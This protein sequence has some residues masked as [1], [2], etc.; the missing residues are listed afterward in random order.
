[1][2]RE[3]FLEDEKYHLRRRRRL[4]RLRREKRLQARRRRLLKK[5]L[6]LGIVALSLIMIAIA[7]ITMVV[8]KLNDKKAQ[9][10][11]NEEAVQVSGNETEAIVPLYRFQKTEDTV[12]IQSEK[13]ISS[14]AILVNESTDMIL[15]V[16]GETER[17]SPASMTKVLTILVAAEHISE[18]NMSDT[19]PMTVEI[20]DYILFNDC[21]AVGFKRGEKVPVKDLF[22]GTVLSS[23][24]DA[25]LGLVNYVAGSQEA[26]VDMMN[27]KLKELGL[28]DTAHFTNAI[29]LYD[30][31]HYC[32]V[33]D[34]AV[35]MK[36]AIK[37]ELCRE[38]LSARTYTTTS[39]IE[40]PEGITI[41]NWFLRRIEDKD[42]GGEV[43]CGKTGYV[44]EAKNCAVSYG[45]LKDETS[46]ICV[47]AG[48]DSVW[49]CIDDQVEI[50]TNYRMESLE[51][52][53]I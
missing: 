35:M 39:T 47:T 48:S 5:L 51:A 24:A 23:G 19:V 15:A 10:A 13:M 32:T 37:N 41:S 26:F 46:Y 52:N 49:T 7:M 42:V 30:E 34:M 27:E 50:Y 14:N 38:I 2:S 1:M 53:E 8:G 33:Y 12:E 4:Q 29:G 6:P 40:H 22:Y 21:S 25:A 18:E 36:A 16:K 11:Q 9:T 3:P 20:M 31:N 43:V 28:S 45:T 17:I 44:K